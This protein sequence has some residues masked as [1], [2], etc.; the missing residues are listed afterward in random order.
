MFPETRLTNISISLKTA[1][2]RLILA[3]MLLGSS[4]CAVETIVHG[5]DEKEANQ[6]LE[7]LDDNAI[8][9]T[10]IMMD[11]GRVISFTVAVPAAKR[12]DAIRILNHHEM[13]RRKDRGY[14]EIFSESGLIPTAAEEKAKKL[15]ALEGEIERQLKLIDGVIDAQVQIVVPEMNALRTNSE[16]APLTTASVTYKYLPGAN[17]EKPLSI[18]QIQALVAAGVEKLEPERVVVIP[19]QAGMGS[20][21]MAAKKTEAEIAPEPGASKIKQKHLNAIAVGVVGL[22]LLLSLGIVYTTMR[23]RVV[24]GRLSRLQTEIA[25]ARRRPGLDEP[26][27]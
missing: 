10:T 12:M 15:S 14:S 2:F 9:G 18:T 24:R 8:V 1:S 22:V 13:P 6:I 5:L 20:A 21:A 7:I 26:S 19:T 4:A 17:G 23:L 16:Q 11:T 25:R 3:L 27:A